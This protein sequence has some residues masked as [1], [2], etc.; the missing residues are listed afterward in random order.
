[1]R[2]TVFSYQK[3]N[4]GDLDNL[5]GCL[6]DIKQISDNQFRFVTQV[7]GKLKGF[8]LIVAV[9]KAVSHLPFSEIDY[10]S[11]IKL[12]ELVPVESQTSDGEQV[13]SLD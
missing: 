10:R 13:D 2:K 1:M 8:Q 11:K 5:L 3:E 9:S 12:L 7:V 4:I 6:W